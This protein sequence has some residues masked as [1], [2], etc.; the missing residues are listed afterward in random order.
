LIRNVKRKNFETWDFI[1]LNHWCSC[2]PHKT[3]FYR[4]S[5]SLGKKSLQTSV[6]YNFPC[7]RI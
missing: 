3:W 5:T 1:S 7:E 4:D 6:E 2:E